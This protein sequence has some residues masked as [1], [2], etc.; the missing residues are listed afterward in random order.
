A[1]ALALVGEE[2]EDI[3]SLQRAADRATEL[4]TAVI[5]M[6][7]RVTAF[8]VRI[9]FIG[10]E[11]RIT[12]VAEDRTVIGVRSRFG[13]HVDGPAFRATVLRREALRADLELL[14]GF[15]R[16]LHDRSADG[17]VFVVNAVDCD[18]NVAS[19]FAVDGENRVTVLGWIVGIGGFHTGYKVSQVRHVA[20]N[21]RQ[22]LH[23]ARRDV[24]AHVGL[25]RVE[26]RSFRRDFH[27]FSGGA[28]FQRELLSSGG[29]YKCFDFVRGFGAEASHFRL[30][31][32][33][34]GR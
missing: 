27:R 20:A 19:T 24:L 25:L 12:E 13:N 26:Q 30:Y 10:I 16:K 34:A 17:V 15:Q 11:N 6:L 1:L 29:A 33:E 8:A 28:Y 2:S 22:R 31:G 3:V 18:I 9:F 4:L 7:Q 21:H 5:R 14:H 23:F 32:V